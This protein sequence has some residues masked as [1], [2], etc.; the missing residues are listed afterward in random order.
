MNAPNSHDIKVLNHLAVGAVD[1]ADGYAEAAA[2]TEDPRYR[3]LFLRRSAERRQVASDLQAAVRGMGG[4]PE[5]EGSILAKAQRAF[6]D[7]KHALMRDEASVVGSIES[8]EAHLQ[9]RFDRAL[10]DEALSATTREAI[11]RAHAAVR[12]GQDEMHVLRRSLE[13]RQ[14]ADNPLYPQ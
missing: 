6:M 14:D 9:A 4:H 1:S 12:T 13:G 3:D 2:E 5:D 11:R 8:G 10:S 7:I